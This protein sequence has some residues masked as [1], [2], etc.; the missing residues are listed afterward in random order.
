MSD[1]DNAR[2]IEIIQSWQSHAFQPAWTENWNGA[3]VRY[4][5]LAGATATLTDSGSLTTL[6]AAGS[7]LFRDRP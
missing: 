1:V 4:G 6:T 5:G 3:L 7:M 2:L